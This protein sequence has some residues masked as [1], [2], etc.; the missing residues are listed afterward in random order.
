MQ[1][2]FE[3]MHPDEFRVR[4]AKFGHPWQTYG[5]HDKR[6]D[7]MQTARDL[8]DSGEYDVIA[9]EPHVSAAGMFQTHPMQRVWTRS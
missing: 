8:D 4:V 6:A 5:K 3:D 1:L 9:I 7:A 2:L